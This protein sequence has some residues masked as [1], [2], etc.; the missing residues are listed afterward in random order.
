[1]NRDSLKI[2]SFA[3]LVMLATSANALRVDWKH[4]E[5]VGTDTPL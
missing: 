1:M 2:F 5:D 3:G 4:Y